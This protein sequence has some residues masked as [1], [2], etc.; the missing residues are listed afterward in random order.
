MA[1]DDVVVACLA[2]D[3]VAALSTGWLA[4][5]RHL[6]RVIIITIAIWGLAIIAFGFVTVFWLALYVFV[7]I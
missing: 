7:N 2:K 3:L 6:G 5:V 4:H 1:A